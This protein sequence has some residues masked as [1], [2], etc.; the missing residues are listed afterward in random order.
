MFSLSGYC[1]TWYEINLF[2]IWQMFWIC[3]HCVQ[4]LFNPLNSICCKIKPL[5]PWLTSQPSLKFGRTKQEK[6]ELSC[7]AKFSFPNSM[8]VK[9]LDKHPY[10]KRVNPLLFF[11]SVQGRRHANETRHGN[12][13]NL[14]LHFSTIIYYFALRFRLWYSINEY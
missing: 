8:T 7:S 13:T 6:G 1:I 10:T 4:S 11:K 9:L 14:N 3:G 2:F 12:G 5:R